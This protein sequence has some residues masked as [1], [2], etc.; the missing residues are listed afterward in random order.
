VGVTFCNVKELVNVAGIFSVTDGRRMLFLSILFLL[1]NG[2]KMFEVLGI[3]N[4]HVLQ[5][6]IVKEAGRSL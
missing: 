3:L 1:I 2:I 5:F 4:D 6:M